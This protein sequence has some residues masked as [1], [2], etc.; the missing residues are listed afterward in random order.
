MANAVPA[1]ALL[2][3]VPSVL[4]SQ[5]ILGSCHQAATPSS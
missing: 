1:V 5:K 4:L 3:S 2:E